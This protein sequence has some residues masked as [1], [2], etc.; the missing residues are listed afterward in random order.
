[1]SKDNNG[2]EWLKKGNRTFKLKRWE[3]PLS[4]CVL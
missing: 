3:L 4:P 1:M 2:S